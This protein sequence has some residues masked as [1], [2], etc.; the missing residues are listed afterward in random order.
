[1]AP[2]SSTFPDDAK[3]AALRAWYA[4]LEAHASVSRY[5]AHEARPVGA[6]S[7]G[8]LERIRRQLIDFA[9]ARH[10][11]DL[12]AIFTSRP[13]R[14]TVDTIP[15][16]IETL[17]QLPLPVPQI[18][19]AVEMWLSP[20]TVRVLHAHGIRTLS[21][22]T[23]RI[24]RRRRWWSAIDGLGVSAAHHVEAFFAA[25]PTL[26]ERARALI[27]AAPTGHVT[28]WEHLRVPHDVDGSRGAV[29]SAAIH[30]SARRVERL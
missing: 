18:T 20:R 24:P 22:L 29:P 27:V 12:A 6:S 1:M 7:R 11:P 14:R 25:H 4:G 17:R 19:D 16:A 9:K 10:R 2:E 23:V 30:K 15:R 28:P 26:T 3:L 8:I 13:S 21:D 5:L